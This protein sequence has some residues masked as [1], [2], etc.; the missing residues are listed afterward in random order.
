MAGFGRQLRCGDEECWEELTLGVPA[1][2]PKTASD[3]LV[4]RIEH[5][6][7]RIP[8][9]STFRAI[10]SRSPDLDPRA[11]AGVPV[12][13]GFFGRALERPLDRADTAPGTGPEMH[14]LRLLY[15]VSRKR[16]SSAR[17]LTRHSHRRGRGTSWKR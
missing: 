3:K 9:L 5:M 7:I 15:S 8:W 1:R 6:V 4:R 17:L 16:V 10:V 12:R 13:R 2:T 11:A 14:R